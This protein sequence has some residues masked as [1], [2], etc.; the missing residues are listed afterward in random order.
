MPKH[1]KKINFFFLIYEVLLKIFNKFK[2]IFILKV[3]IKKIPHASATPTLARRT[4]REI[5]VL[6]YISHPNIV[7]LKDVFRTKS[8]TGLLG[9]NVFLV[10][11]LMEG[12]LHQ[13]IHGCA[14]EP[15][16]YKLIAHLL[17]QIL[18]GL[19]VNFFNFEDIKKNLVL[20]FTHSRNCPSRFK[21]FKFVG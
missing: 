2:K 4:L 16:E 14:A 10:M 12:S 21:T 19:R 8:N 5:R 6:R 7:T 13:V 18:R 20:V 15:L 11:N 17:Y 1:S 3:A 9:L